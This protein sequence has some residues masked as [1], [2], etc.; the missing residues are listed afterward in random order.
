MPARREADN[1]DAVGIDIPLLGP[2]PHRADSALGVEQ[3]HERLA[4]G[5][6][7]FQDNAGD[8]VLVEPLGDAV[9][10]GDYNQAAV[11][12]ARADHGRRPVGFLGTGLMDR[13]QSMGRLKGPV[14]HRCRPGPIESAATVCGARSLTRPVDP[15]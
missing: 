14:A 8:A 4:A 5:E 3:R 10:F 11:A 12:T 9:P 15:G 6:S 13:E 7:V 1:A 2:D